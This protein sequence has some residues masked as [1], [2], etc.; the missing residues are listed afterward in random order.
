MALFK[1]WDWD[2]KSAMHDVSLKMFSREFWVELETFMC[3]FPC[4]AKADPVTGGHEDGCVMGLCHDYVPYFVYMYTK[5]V[6]VPGMATPT[7][8]ELRQSLISD[9]SYY[10]SPGGITDYEYF[11]ATACRS[12]AKFILDHVD[13]YYEDE[14]V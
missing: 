5:N 12:L 11:E 9:L 3:K 14:D 13:K 6:M 10:A 4:W 8:S 1:E 7:L 2:A